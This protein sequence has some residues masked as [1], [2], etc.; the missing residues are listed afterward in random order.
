MTT[1]AALSFEQKT[2]DILSVILAGDWRLS[3]N[4]PGV[5]T[6]QAAVDKTSSLRTMVLDAGQITDWDSGLLTFLLHLRQLCTD[7]NLAL[8]SSDLPPGALKLLA[9][10]AAVP[11]K[12]MRAKRRS[13]ANFSRRSA[14]RASSWF[15]RPEIC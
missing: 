7:K 3:N 5:N 4:L 9:L 14:M 12:K 15:T 10:A 1:D 11:E 13:A 8:D 6:V 2:P